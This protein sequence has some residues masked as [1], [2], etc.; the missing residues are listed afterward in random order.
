MGKISISSDLCILE[1]CL[2]G[3]IGKQFSRLYGFS[4]AF[5]DWFYECCAQSSEEFTIMVGERIP[6]ILSWK[7]LTS[8]NSTKVSEMLSATKV[9]LFTIINNHIITICLI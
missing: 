2:R 7:V 4:L 9:I 1:K 8:P 6:R 3:K 5:Q